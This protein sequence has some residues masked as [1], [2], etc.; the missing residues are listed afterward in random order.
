MTLP[1]VTIVSD[2]EAETA[3]CVVCMLAD[4][5]TPFSDNVF[6]VCADCSSAIQHRPYAPKK[7]RK[8]CI[9]CAMARVTG[10]NA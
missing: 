2:E 6:T 3:D 8:L 1:D 7:P 5:P 10:G 9:D 4:Y